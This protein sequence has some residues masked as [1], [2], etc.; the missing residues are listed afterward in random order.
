MIVLEDT[1]T[2]L[3]THSLTLREHRCLCT[4]FLFVFCRGEQV[5]PR[6]VGAQL[7]YF[8]QPTQGGGQGRCECV[9]VC[10]CIRQK[11]P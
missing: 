4:L 8:L 11:F 2:H 9:F 1:A 7:Q 10:A 6:G 3:L 5:G